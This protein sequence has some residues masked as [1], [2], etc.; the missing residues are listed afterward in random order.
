MKTN[1]SLNQVQQSTYAMLVRS[2]EKGSLFEA[3]A[4]GLTVLSAVIA[5]W[6]FAAQPVKLPVDLPHTASVAQTEVVS[7]S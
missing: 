2:E 7:Q 3:V 6:Q 4:Y 1:K 5:I